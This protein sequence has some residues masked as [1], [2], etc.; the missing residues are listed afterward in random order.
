MLVPADFVCKIILQRRF[1]Q[2]NLLFFFYFLQ[3]FFN[4]FVFH[5]Y[6]FFCKH[7]ALLLISFFFNS[8]IILWNLAFLH[9]RWTD[10]DADCAI[11]LFI[12]FHICFCLNFVWVYSIETKSVGAGAFTIFCF[13]LGSLQYKLQ[14]KVIS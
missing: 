9:G 11:F 5:L 7:N 10:V 1:F 12:T 2:R 6:S 14:L 8:N 3:L 13:A 4:L